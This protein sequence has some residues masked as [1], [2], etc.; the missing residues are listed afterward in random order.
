MTK[1]KHQRRSAG[2]H[3]T[4]C[5]GGRTKKKRGQPLLSAKDLYPDDWEPAIPHEQAALPTRSM[6]GSIWK[7]LVLQ[8]RYEYGIP[9]VVD[10]DGQ[11]LV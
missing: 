7:I 4:G 5:R 10:G 3:T 11:E 6:P 2:N 1:P 9:L 8:A